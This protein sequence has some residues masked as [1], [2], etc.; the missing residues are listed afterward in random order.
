MSVSEKVTTATAATAAATAAA[1]AAA[2]AAATAAAATTAAT[3]AATTAAAT[4]ATRQSAA[5]VATASSTT[6]YE[7]KTSDINSSE[8]SESIRITDV[9]RQRLLDLPKD[10]TKQML[11]A[12]AISSKQGM[13][14]AEHCSNQIEPAYNREKYNS[15]RVFLTRI[16]VCGQKNVERINYRLVTC[17][18]QY[19]DS[20]I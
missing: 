18:S 4:A 3:A 15:T 7:N 20:T 10:W 8:S 17:T 16:N 12:H 5:T 19:A 1:A 6:T 14:D 11:V 13:A 2:T 9:E